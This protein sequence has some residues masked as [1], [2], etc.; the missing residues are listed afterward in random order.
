MK[1][2]L[3]YI[4]SQIGMIPATI[5]FVNAG[6]QLSSIK[7]LEDIFSVKII[8]SFTLLGILPLMGKWLFSFLR[9]V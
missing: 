8:V 9:K 7:A 5:I 3:F 1:A 4:V 6:T 2:S